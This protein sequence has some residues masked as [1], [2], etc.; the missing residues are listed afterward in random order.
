[1]VFLANPVPAFGGYLGSL[2]SSDGSHVHHLSL[3]VT[4]ITEL[5]W[6]PHPIHDLLSE[7]V[8]L[9]KT[10]RCLHTT[11]GTNFSSAHFVLT[12]G[13]MMEECATCLL[14]N[15]APK[16]PRPIGRYSH[17]PLVSGYVI[18]TTYRLRAWLLCLFA[19]SLFLGLLLLVL[20]L[21]WFSL[22]CLLFSSLYFPRSVST[23]ST[24]VIYLINSLPINSPYISSN[25]L[26]M[27]L[28]DISIF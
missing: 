10:K 7:L 6:L 12:L 4:S 17:C 27:G 22:P 3:G 13:V 8:E 26:T 23:L 14:L 2:D 9:H 24:F 20:A 1:M 21:S 11:N 15:R 25:L 28:D 18:A 5:M 16:H 19:L